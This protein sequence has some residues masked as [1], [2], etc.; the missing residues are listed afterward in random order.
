MNIND[1]ETLILLR[2][3]G[4]IT[5]ADLI[6]LNDALA[7]DPAAAGHARRLDRLAT[8]AR[9]PAEDAALPAFVRERILHEARSL[10]KPG[11]HTERR[12]HQ[13]SFGVRLAAA[14]AVALL[15]GLP[16]LFF[17]VSKP[18]PAVLV[19]LST[20]PAPLDDGML[21]AIVDDGLAADVD[22]LRLTLAAGLSVR[23]DLTLATADEDELLNQLASSLM[24]E[25]M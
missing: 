21:A 5:P 8:L 10:A 19:K 1:I 2:Q 18:S 23:D 17:G 15:L 24:L 14:A 11:E 7:A 3:S 16:L 12:R 4:E 25:K 6:R 20:T 22:A 13:W 9:A